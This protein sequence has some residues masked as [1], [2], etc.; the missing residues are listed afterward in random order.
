MQGL[1][2]VEVLVAASIIL[3]ALSAMIG[4]FNVYMR[5]AYSNATAAKAA[6][7]AE[8]GVEAVKLMRDTSWATNIAPLALDT[9]YALA[10]GTSTWAATTTKIYIDNTFLRT[11]RLSSV[12]RNVS[13]DIDPA[14]TLDVGTKLLTMTVAWSAGTATSTKSIATYITNFNN[15]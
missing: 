14:G 6:Y 12:Q 13:S 9:D 11:F 1:T 2:L 15:D 8:E 10:F 3:V 4:V 7:L 5:I